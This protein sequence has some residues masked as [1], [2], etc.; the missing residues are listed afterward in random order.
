MPNGAKRWCFTLNNPSSDEALVLGNYWTNNHAQ[1]LI[2]GREVGQSGT[3]HYQGYVIFHERKTLSHVR[4]TLER[5]HWEISRGTPK[6]ASDYCK[7]EG[8]YEEHG[9]LPSGQ[10]KR[11]DWERLREYV[12]QHGRPRQREL[13]LEFPALM[14]RYEHGVQC[15]LSALSPIPTLTN[16]SPREGWQSDLYD[17]LQGPPHD[18]EIEFVIDYDGGK[19]K[20]W[21][22]AHMFDKRPDDVQLLRIGKRD[23]LAHAIDPQKTIFLIDVPR[24][25]MEFLQYSILESLKDRIVFSPKY[26]S[27]TKVLV[28]RP[29][30]VVFCNEDPD[31]TKMSVDRYFTNYV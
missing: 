17:K 22:C 31:L 26:H 30:V 3:P 8:D 20:S 28:G 29:H 4:N 12:E 13:W 27:A 1:Y 24:T 5:A 21:F 7:K 23:D 2:Y 14:G 19:G 10:G 18:R 6:Q 15:Y 9:S 16:T 11:N 25:Q